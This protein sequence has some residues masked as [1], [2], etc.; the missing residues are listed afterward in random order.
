[1]SK[2]T[3]TDTLIIGAGLTGLTAAYHLQKQ[4]RE[5]LIAE[6]RSRLG[7]RIHTADLDTNRPIELG[8]TWLGVKHTQLYK[9]LEELGIKTF[10]QI[11]GDKVIYEAISTSPP[12]LASLPPNPEPSLRIVGGSS[13]LISSLAEKLDPE[14]IMLDTV[15]KQIDL[16]DNHLVA[17][18]DGLEITCKDIISTLPPNLFINT[19]KCNPALP[20]ELTSLAKQTHTWMGESIK[21]ALRYAEPFWRA[22]NSSGTIMSNV[23]PIPEM[24]D[25][26][27][28]EETHYALMGFLNG[29]FHSL[30]EEERQQLVTKQLTK[31]Y[32]KV[33][34]QFISYHETV[35]RN[36]PYS[37]YPNEN[38]VLPHQ[39]NGHPLFAKPYLEGHLYLAGT[40]TSQ[41]YPGYMEGAIHSAQQ[42][43]QNL[44]STV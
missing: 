22:K 4:G 39:N 25:H 26:S 29:A 15:I 10:E 30:T 3:Q 12:Y 37:Y 19:I 35:W 13:T 1:M 17:F 42:V 38:H 9:L 14:S 8:A 18:S 24:Y 27:N 6:A 21:I 32:G 7:G 5:V 40:E 36:E 16:K 41:Y 34:E 43:V 28:A 44:L 31:Y 33:A 23:G 2:T 11:I 20:E